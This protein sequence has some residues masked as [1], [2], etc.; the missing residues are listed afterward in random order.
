LFELGL[1][2]SLGALNDENELTSDEYIEKIDVM[3]KSSAKLTKSV[4]GSRTRATG[5]PAN[6]LPVSDDLDRALIARLQ[7]NA[8]ESTANLARALGTARTTIVARLARLESSGVVLGYT[9]KLASDAPGS[10]NALTA[11]VSLTVELK[12]GPSVEKRI[13]RIPEVRQLLAVSGPYDYIAVV[14]A[15]SAMQLNGLLDEL[16]Q[17]DGVVR[18]QSAIVL[19]AKVD[20]L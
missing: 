18:T 4:R 7:A 3:T 19:Q 5:K 1:R 15:A 13:A 14:R 11:H 9:A 17:I 6:A 2:Q 16:G 10:A 12:A 20:R 8:R